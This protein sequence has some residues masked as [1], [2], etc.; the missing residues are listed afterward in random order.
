MSDQITLTLPDGTP[1]E[2]PRGTT[3]LE[4]AEK[5]GSR[6]AKAAVAAGLDGKIVDLAAPISEEMSAFRIVE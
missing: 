4:A 5:I 2:V 1:L 3:A 6:L